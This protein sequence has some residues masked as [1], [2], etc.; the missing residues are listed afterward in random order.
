MLARQDA[1]SHSGLPFTP[2]Q[3][4]VHVRTFT[5][6]SGTFDDH[7]HA[8]NLAMTIEGPAVARHR[9]D[10]V[11]VLEE[12][13]EAVASLL[14]KAGIAFTHESSWLPDT[15]D[16]IAGYHDAP[17]SWDEDGDA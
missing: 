15:E 17:A 11:A 16:W 2:F 3:T 4:M 1:T 8:A 6:T 5:T 14:R 9:E 12:N 7:Q 10:M 13:G